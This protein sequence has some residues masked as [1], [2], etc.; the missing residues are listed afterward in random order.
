MPKKPIK[1]TIHAKGIDIGIYTNDFQNEFISLTDIAK[2]RS[3]DP[4][5]T[6]CNWMRNRDTLEFLGL[7]ETLHNPDFKP[8]EFEGFRSQAGLNAFTMSPSKWINNVSA[9]G[10]VSKA[11]RYGGTYAHSDIAFEFAS[12][13]SAEFKLYIIKDYQRIKTDENSRLSLNWNLNREISKLNYRIHTDAI[14][15]N[16]IPPELTKEQIAY[17]YAN[18]ADML[19]VALF[20]ITA[21]QWREMNP[22]KKGNM[23]DDANL[24]Q[25]LVLS[26]MESYNAVLIEQGKAQSDR[27]VLLRDLAVKQMK[28]MESLTMTGLAML[29]KKED[30]Q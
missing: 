16:L 26:N 29:T 7:W 6:I 13:I 9:I 30:D 18:E 19:N 21:K 24:N 23:R 20:G 14:K 4:N 3:D 11:G 28:T 1:E 2:Y 17:T 12:W 22:D 15:E 8:L 5:A 27:L 10:I 25:L